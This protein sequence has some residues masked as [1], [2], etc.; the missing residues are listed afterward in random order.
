MG[1]SLQNRERWCHG[2]PRGRVGQQ[3][4]ES[5]GALIGSKQAEA[6]DEERATW[7]C[8]EGASEL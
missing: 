1:S 4:D 2:R 5:E 8:L 7:P 6:C 3:D